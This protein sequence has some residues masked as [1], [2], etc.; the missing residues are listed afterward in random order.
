[1]VFNRAD[2]IVWAGGVAAQSSGL[3]VAA[4]SVVGTGL[5]WFS[6]GTSE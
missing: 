2:R 4:F 5:E 1:M 6:A 3:V